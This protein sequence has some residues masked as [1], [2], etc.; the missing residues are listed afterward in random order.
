MEIPTG[1]SDLNSLIDGPLTP[2]QR[3]QW[4]NGSKVAIPITVDFAE[5]GNI[6]V[7][8]PPGGQI[9]L[10]LGEKP[11]SV[12]LDKPDANPFLAARNTD[13]DIGAG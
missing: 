2:G 7:V 11:F 4:V 9:T 1:T 8:V 6:S 10:T 5:R 13:G 12:T 3:L